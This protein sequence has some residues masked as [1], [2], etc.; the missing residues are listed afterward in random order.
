MSFILIRSNQEKVP[1]KIVAYPGESDRGPFPIPHELPIEGWPA[2]VQRSEKHKNM[3]LDDVQRDK[4]MEGGA[5]HSI[6]VDPGNRSCTSIS[7]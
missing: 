1:V 2:F 5:R 6:V 3:T 4:L 7:E